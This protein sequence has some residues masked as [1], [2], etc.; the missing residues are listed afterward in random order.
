MRLSRFAGKTY[1]DRLGGFD[2]LL[3]MRT[4]S[5]PGRLAARRVAGDPAWL[6]EFDKVRLP[7]NVGILAQATAAFA[8]NEQAVL[9]E[10][11]ARIRADRETL[12]RELK[13]LP[14]IRVWPSQANFIL[15]R[16][17]SG[18]AA[19]VFEALLAAG[20]L[21]KNLAATGGALAGCLRVTVGTPSE[22]AAFLQ[23][24]RVAL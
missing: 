13:T 21:I 17:E 5:R 16:V 6:R 4:L 24:L 9:D 15:F 19:R 22:N 12:M 20:V 3:V 2:N 7:Y 23:A 8:L 14:G 10:Q 1:M 11:A 18:G